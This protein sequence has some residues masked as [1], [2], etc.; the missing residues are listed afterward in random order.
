M[1]MLVMSELLE[2]K[3]VRLLI[4]LIYSEDAPI[5]DC[6]KRLEEKFEETDFI[7]EEYNFDFTSYYEE[8]MGKGL[9][10]RLTSPVHKCTDAEMVFRTEYVMLRS[11]RHGNTPDPARLRVVASAS[12]RSGGGPY[13]PRSRS[14]FRK[15]GP[16]V[17][18]R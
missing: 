5:D 14:D 4:G 7:S 15:A 6:I 1:L 18:R 2:P 12:T 16:P 9:S 17:L 3:P 8:E 10:R 11:E 13:F